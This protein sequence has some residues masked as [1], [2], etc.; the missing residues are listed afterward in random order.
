M[1]KRNDISNLHSKFKDHNNK[2][3]KMVTFNFLTP[4]PHFF[5]HQNECKE[6]TLDYLD[7]LGYFL[8]VFGVTEKNLKVNHPL[9]RMRV[10]NNWPIF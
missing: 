5:F 9:G 2:F 10:N 4:L 8:V 1:R 6:C 3:F 7:G